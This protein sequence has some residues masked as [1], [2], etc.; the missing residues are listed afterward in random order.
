MSKKL[1]YDVHRN[2]GGKQ[3]M[4]KLTSYM[5]RT[6]GLTYT[7]GLAQGLTSLRACNR[8]WSMLKQAQYQRMAYLQPQL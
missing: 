4:Q 3:N 6:I 7:T 8:V 1:Y 2:N 5:H